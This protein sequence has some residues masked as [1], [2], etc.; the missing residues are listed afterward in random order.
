LSMSSV[1][2]SIIERSEDVTFLARFSGPSTRSSSGVPWREPSRELPRIDASGNEQRGATAHAD[3]KRW[4]AGDHR[5]N[6]TFR[7]ATHQPA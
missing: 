3:L 2:C 1:S 5:S 4:L 7:A 6:N